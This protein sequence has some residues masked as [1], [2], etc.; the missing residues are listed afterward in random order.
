MKNY[1]SSALD[2]G[3]R[4]KITFSQYLRVSLI[5]KGNIPTES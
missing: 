4:S 1:I 2:D 3:E 5:A